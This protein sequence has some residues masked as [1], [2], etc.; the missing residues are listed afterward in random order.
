MRLRGV[1]RARVY[2]GGRV[3]GAV[4][5]LAAI[6]ASS[7]GAGSARAVSPPHRNIAVAARERDELTSLPHR[8]RPLPTASAVAVP[9]PAPQPPVAPR[10][11]VQARAPAQTVPRA[12]APAPRPPAFTD[13]ASAAQAVFAAINTSRAAAGLPPLLWSA[14]LSRSAHL[15]NL[16]MAAA[17]QMSHQLP[18]EAPL[19]NRISAQGV[20]WTWAGENI[21]VTSN[22]STAGAL[23]IEQGMVSETPPNDEHRLNIL[24]TYGTM[25]GVD[26]VFDSIHH[27]LW[28]TEDFAN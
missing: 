23:G 21:A 4:L 27:L 25:V 20:G 5:V 14:G 2:A 11:P 8:P 16:A 18:G 1:S 22:L 10:P 26:V 9:T 12:P 6:V 7:G 17:N 13:S 24:T 19:G 3:A 28:L 15:H